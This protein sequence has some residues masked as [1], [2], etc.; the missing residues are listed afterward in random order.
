MVK[1]LADRQ[2]GGYRTSVLCDGVI[3]QFFG[4]GRPMR[5]LSRDSTQLAIADQVQTFLDNV[6]IESVLNITRHWHQPERRVDSPVLKR[7]R[8]W[9]HTLYFNYSDHCVLR[10]PQDGLFKCWYEDMEGPLPGV[11]SNFG[12]FCRKLYAE[13]VD[14]LRWR[15]PELDLYEMDGRKTNI[16]LGDPDHGQACSGTVVI[17]PNPPTPDQ[18]FRMMYERIW[19][20]GAETRATMEAVH[21]PDGIHW[22]AYP[23]LPT[24]GS[25]G[26]KLGDVVLFFYDRYAREFVQT[27]RH[28]FIEAG[29]TNPHVPRSRSFFQ[30]REPHNPAADNQRRIWQ[31]RSHDFIHWSEPI[32]IA[33]TDD[34]EDNLDE[35]YYGMPMSQMG[36]IYLGRLASSAPSTT[37][38]TCSS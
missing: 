36:S 9:E 25:A 26:R 6:L 29:H 37:R 34:E 17:D 12:R 20:R 28:T 21:S 19:E 22:Q 31:T 7:E 27:T 15:R 24:F 35:S 23:E 18:R 13:S 38:C 1:A 8:P 11:R 32:L 4:R 5:D 3:R 2:R 30:P 33:A 10:D 16:V 14:G